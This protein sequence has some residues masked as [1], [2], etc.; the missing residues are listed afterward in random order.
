MKNIPLK[1]AVLLNETFDKVLMVQPWKGDK[2]TSNKWTFPRGKINKGETGVDC[3]IREVWEETGIDIT[4]HVDASE[5]VRADI[6]GSGCA[7]QL[8]LVPGIAEKA[9]APTANKEISRIAWIPLT[10]LPGWNEAKD[11]AF[12]QFFCVKSFVPGIKKWV[13]SRLSP[14]PKPAVPLLGPA[15]AFELDMQKLMSAWD[16]CWE[17]ASAATVP[18][19]GTQRLSH[20]APR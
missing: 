9:C 4:G 11:E 1:G 8:F 17:E 14:Q 13:N 20:R 19:R 6:Y 10:R 12:L 7:L 5:Y 3:A 2:D 15:P 16:R 18:Q